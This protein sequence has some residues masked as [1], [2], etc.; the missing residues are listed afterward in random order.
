MK[1]RQ[2]LQLYLFLLHAAFFGLVLWVLHSKPLLVIVVELCLLLSFGIGFLVLRRALL[3][4]EFARQFKDLLHDE[5]YAARLKASRNHEVSE[6]ADLFNR[7]LDHL[8]QERLR[9]GEQ[10]GFLEKLLEATPGA[11]VVFDFEGKVSLC[12]VFAQELFGA[13]IQLGDQLGSAEQAS[14]FVLDLAALKVGESQVLS[15]EEGRRF[16]CQRSQFIDRGFAREFLLIDEITEELASSEKATYEKLV[17]VLAHEVN[18][19]VA[20]TGSVLESLLY[21]RAQLGAEDA[22]DFETAVTAVRRRNSSLAQFIA[23]FTEVVKMPEPRLQACDIA[24]M[25][26]TAIVLYRQRCHEL[27]IRLEW[28]QRDSLPAQMIDAHLF[29]QVLLNILKNAI[30]AVEI[31]IKA[32]PDQASEARYVFIELGQD[33]ELGLVRLSVIDSGRGLQNIPTSQL[34]TPFFTTK[35]GGQGIGLMF[36]REVLN[37]HGFT[38]RLAMNA[39]GDTQF[40]IFFNF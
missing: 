32:N 7:M 25:L 16:R 14:A 12:N 10:R 20:A 6:L 1:L 36:V 28:Q 26:D 19:T 18:N 37:R 40:D 21:Y 24:E 13:Q 5:N 9:I 30:E 4:L 27:G 31:S 3:P 8:Y 35:K 23:R 29:E 2:Q 38:H 11:V 34:F 39:M 22:Q 33:T 15:N 17:R